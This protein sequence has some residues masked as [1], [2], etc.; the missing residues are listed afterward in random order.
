MN[1][2]RACW[3]VWRACAQGPRRRPPGSGRARIPSRTQ[4]PRYRSPSQ[5]RRGPVRRGTASGLAVGTAGRTAFGESRAQGVGHGEDKLSQA[6]AR[7][8]VRQQVERGGCHPTAHARGAERARAA[9]ERDQVPIATVPA[10]DQSEA[11]LKEP[12]ANADF[13]SVAFAPPAAVAASVAGVV[14]TLGRD[15]SCGSCCPSGAGAGS[16][17]SAW[18]T[19]SNAIYADDMSHVWSAM[20]SLLGDFRPDRATR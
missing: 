4:P 20:E 15:W 11:S 3:A 12:A 1:A 16:G 8:H 13:Q 10:S 6:N 14:A 18:S 2:L 9:T 5:G 7:D 17:T 19:F